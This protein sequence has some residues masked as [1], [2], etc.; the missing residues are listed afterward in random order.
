MNRNREKLFLK[1][2]IIK[3]SNGMATI[4]RLRAKNSRTVDFRE[5]EGGFGNWG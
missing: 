3:G 5:R 1:W 4:L 2:N